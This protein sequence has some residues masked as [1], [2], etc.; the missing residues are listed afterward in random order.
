MRKSVQAGLDKF[1]ALVLVLLILFGATSWLALPVSASSTALCAEDEVE[2]AASDIPT[3]YKGA[4]FHKL[5]SSSGDWYGVEGV[6]RFG[7]PV[8]DPRRYDPKTDWSFDGSNVYVG[9][10]AGGEEV[11]CGLHW[12]AA[13]DKNG[14]RL[15]KGGYIPFYRN[16]S[17]NEPDA[18]KRVY[19]YPGELAQ[20]SVVVDGP[21]TLKLS[22]SDP[23]DSA[24]TYSMVFLA[25]RFGMGL[26][27]SFKRVNDLAQHG[28]EGKPVVPTESKVVNATWTESY[29]LWKEQ[30]QIMRVPINSLH[31]M[32]I[33]L[34]RS[35]NIKVSSLAEQSA[36]GGET[37]SVYGDPKDAQAKGSQLSFA[38]KSSKRG[39][40][41]ALRK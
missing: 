29:F 26:P 20:M 37:V 14:N 3:P 17:W 24:K 36:N 32:V 30:G 9:G 40:K 19:W 27:T 8:L 38:R 41:L 10:N 33:N 22:I 1:R 5:M 18:E 25:P 16:G 39:E 28:N 12:E 31:A 13:L 15:G 23:E 4:Y 11:D 6:V 7:T 2:A 34:P 21:G 35:Q